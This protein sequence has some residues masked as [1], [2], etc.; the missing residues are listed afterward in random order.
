MHK[1]IYILL[2]FLLFNVVSKAQ[3]TLDTI[4]DCLKQKPTIFAK[5]DSRNSFISNSRAKILGVK[6]GLNYGNRLHIGIGYNQLYPPATD[7]NKQ[8]YYKNSLGLRDSVTARLRLYYIAVYMEYVFYQT[9][10]WS[11]SM[12]LQLG[13]GKTYYK[14]ELYGLKRVR[15]E[16]LNFI[17]EPAVSINYK[18]VKWFGL[19]ADM[20]FRF[21]V[22]GDR[23]LNQK[24][25]APTYA[26]KILIY[27]SEIYRTLFPK[28]RSR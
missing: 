20:G 21:M 18:I 7:F 25:N 13:I 19:G 5:F 23:K 28:K 2:W 6:L 8:V 10:H 17:Y 11:L 3:P 22:T 12:P 9:N 16:N 24:F 1:R 4:K 15:E 27:Y 14:Y 26:F